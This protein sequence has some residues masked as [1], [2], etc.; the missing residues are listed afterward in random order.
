MKLYKK[1][2]K[3][4]HNVYKITY[5]KWQNLHKVIITLIILLFIFFICMIL[6]P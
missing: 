3:F 5:L 1:K 4:F 2:I 6:L